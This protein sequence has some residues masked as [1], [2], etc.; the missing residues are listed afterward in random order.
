M[1]RLCAEEG[2]SGV[3]F[4]ELI[5]ELNGTVHWFVFCCFEAS[6]LY[7]GRRHLVFLEPEV[8]IFGR[9]GGVEQVRS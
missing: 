6:S 4:L 2:N 3:V 8:T 5:L 7:F 1:R 9:E